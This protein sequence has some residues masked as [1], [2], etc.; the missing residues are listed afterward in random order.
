MAQDYTVEQLNHGRRV[1]DFMRWDNVAFTISALLLI[2]SVAIIGVKGFNWGLDF[3]GG[4]VIEVNFSQ[5]ADLDKIR[6]TVAQAG[7]KDPLIQNFGS[8]RDIMVR[9][10]PAEG[11][12]GQELGKT[13]INVINKNIDESAVVKRIEFVGPSVGAELA[14]TGAMAL[15]AALICI[16]IYVAMRF[17]WRLA[18]GAVIALAHDVIITLGVLSLFHIEIDLTIVASLMS[19]IGYSLNDSIVVSDRIRENFRKIRRGTSYEI[20]NVSL[21][22]TLSRT[23]M[24]SATTLLVVLM[25]YIFGGAMLQGFSL[26]M[27]IGVSIGTISSIY[28][29]SALALKL[30]MKREHLIVQKVEKEGADQESILP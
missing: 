18:L 12:A 19:V 1:Y 3:T 27:L 7:F 20:M 25:L 2:A 23:I 14:Q 22:Q 10:P 24:T 30:G 6:D 26:V 29:A 13:V 5:P 21:T 9:L 11:A 28:V 8:S 4:T 15:I 16:L 17:E